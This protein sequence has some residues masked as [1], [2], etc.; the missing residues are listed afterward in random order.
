VEENSAHR[1][2]GNRDLRMCVNG[3]MAN[4]TSK[5]KNATKINQLMLP[6]R[7]RYQREQGTV[8]EPISSGR[9]K[10]GGP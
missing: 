8:K 10:K 2:K 3:T 6:N 5:A 9:R 7:N 4:P 1:G